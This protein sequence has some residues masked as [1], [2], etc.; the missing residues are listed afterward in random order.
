M[1]PI[2]SCHK[3]HSHYIPP[4]PLPDST[5]TDTSIYIDITLDNTRILGIQIINAENP[6]WGQIWPG[7]TG[8]TGDSLVYIGYRIG[9]EFAAAPGFGKLLTN[10]IFFFTKG[11]SANIR[12]LVD[13]S[14]WTS[15]PALDFIDTFFAA[16]NYQYSAK[17]SDTTVTIGMFGTPV[18][19]HLMTNGISI[20]WIDSTGNL[21]TTFNGAADQSGS[22]FT[23]VKNDVPAAPSWGNVTTIT[24]TLD[25]KLY[26]NNGHVIHLTNGKFRQP[27]Y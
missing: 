20:A 18:Q 23:I 16:G 8:Y 24:A 3:D 11:N 7:S 14:N 21:W 2:F 26:D 6:T 9:A 25:C 15:V 17:A 4:A 12:N 5:I 10:Q 27:M 1:V 13:S 19:R 22:Y